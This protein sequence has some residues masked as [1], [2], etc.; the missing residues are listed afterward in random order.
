MEHKSECVELHKTFADIKA[1]WLQQYPNHCQQCRGYGG[2]ESRYD[3]SPSGVSLGSGFMSDF[4]TC[5]LCTDKGICSLCAGKIDEDGVCVAGCDVGRDH[6]G[7][8]PECVCWELQALE[9][10]SGDSCKKA[11]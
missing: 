7:D 11:L 2:S 1:K 5:T 10:N 4:D 6:P 3:P 8:G 9:E